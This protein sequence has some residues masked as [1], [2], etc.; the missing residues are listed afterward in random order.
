M[1]A[2][3]VAMAENVCDTCAG[4][5]LDTCEC[6][7]ECVVC[8]HATVRAYVCAAFHHRHFVSPIFTKRVDNQHLPAP[9]QHLPTPAR[10]LP[11]VFVTPA[12]TGL[13]RWS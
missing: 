10:H 5:L 6:L 1:A 4:I 13:D 3:T 11:K 2:S 7:M 12:D 9:A 8:L